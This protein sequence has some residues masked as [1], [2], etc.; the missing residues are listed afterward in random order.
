MIRKLCSWTLSFVLVFSVSVIVLP[1]LGAFAAGNAFE[2]SFSGGSGSWKPLSGSWSAANG[3]Y[4]Q[5]ATANSTYWTAIKDKRWGD[6]TYEFDMKL[7]NNGGSNLSWAG[8]QFKKMLQDDGPFDSG[9]MLYVR[10]NGTIELYKVNKVLDSAATGLSFTTSRH[11]KIVNNAHNIKVYVNNEAT[12]RIDYT[13][14]TFASGY[15]GL[16]ASTSSWSFDNVS[17]KGGDLPY[18][19]HVGNENL[20]YTDAQMPR[21]P[22]RWMPP[23]PR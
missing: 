23:S 13:D 7:L 22:L 21:C 8:F 17:V 15:S 1:G 5:S 16:A 14:K 3:E 19:I 11:V 9:F 4:V 18:T 10:A 20:L 6:A 2:D 12:P